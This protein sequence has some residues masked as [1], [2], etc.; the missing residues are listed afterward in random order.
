MRPRIP[1]GRRHSC[2]TR[3]RRGVDQLNARYGARP[4][5]PVPSRAAMER[6]RT[7]L[8]GMGAQA[9]QARRSSTACCAART[10]T[11]F[12]VASR[13]PRRCCRRFATSSRS[14]PTRSC[15]CDAARRLVG[16]ARA[17]AQPAALRSSAAARRPRA[18]ASCSRASAS[19]CVS[20]NRTRF[21][22]VFSGH[23]GIDPYT[24]RGVG[25]LP[26]SLPRGQLRRQG[27][28]R[29][30][31]VRGRARRTRAREPRCSA[32][33][34]SRASTRAPALVHRHPAASTIIRRTTRRSRRGSTAGSA[35][36]GRSS[37]WLLAHACPMR[38]AR[39]AVREY[40]AAA[41]RA[42]RSSTTCAAACCRRRLWRCSLAGWT[43]LPGAPALLDAAGAAGARV[44]GVH[45][46]SARSLGEPRAR[47]CRCAT[48]RR[49]ERDALVHESRAG[50]VSRSS[51][52]AHQAVVHG[53]TRSAARSWRLLVTRRG[54]LEW[55]RRPIGAATGASTRGTR[56]AHDVAGAGARAG[57]RRCSRVAWSRRHALLARRCR[58]CCCGSSRRSSSWWAEHG[59]WR[60]PAAR[61]RTRNA[62]TLRVLARQHLAVLRDVRRRRP[63]NWLPPDNFQE[64]RQDAASRTARRRRTSACQLL[65]ARSRPTTSAT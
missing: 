30:R 61:R 47:V 15:R 29:R 50:R 51:L 12:T 10:D 58:C 24:T 37:G 64:D 26:G 25:R 11:S 7:S 16:D 17:S 3:A 32:T 13:R 57:D 28:L 9:R 49:A 42:G 39:H 19:A 38:T 8:D 43:C 20:A 53:S 33:I 60:T 31:R 46:A 52:L 27:H 56:S 36:T 6:G 40:A 45:P 14:T 2:R 55:S 21:A 5:L 1:D 4:L 23:V 54:L 62:L 48:H 41:L 63:I 65:V 35:A 44:S 22:Q 59:R 18:T 34:S